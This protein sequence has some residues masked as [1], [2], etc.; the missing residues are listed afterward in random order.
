MAR[1]REKMTEKQLRYSRAHWRVEGVSVTLEYC[2]TSAHEELTTTEDRTFAYN[3]MEMQGVDYKVE[4][5][6]GLFV[7]LS[8]YTPGQATSLVSAP[9]PNPR[10]I[11]DTEEPPKG[12]NF[13]DGDLFFLISGNNVIS[14]RVGA[15]ESVIQ[16]FISK[17]LL[18]SSHKALFDAFSMEKILNYDKVKLLKTEGVKKIYMRGSLYE[19]SLSRLEKKVKSAML[20]VIPQGLL[21][22]FGDD[23]E[24]K[25]IHADENVNVH[26]TL[27]WDKRKKGGSIGQERLEKVAER[28]INEHEPD[29]FIIETLKGKTLTADEMR[30]SKTIRLVPRGK[31]VDCGAVWQ[32]ISN[33]YQEL[34]GSG[35]LEQ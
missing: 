32:E 29:G 13:M 5:G 35:M 11:T 7:Q 28:L 8:L 31:S 34:G 18:N 4:K 12:K 23:N 3:A 10:G 16:A 21:E 14:C 15:S 27:S 26:V 1:S 20:S 30:I 24:L 6:V 2:L 25:T 17:M 22:I 9:A 33:Y 19:A